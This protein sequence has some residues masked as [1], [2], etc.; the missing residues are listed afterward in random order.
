VT[1][2]ADQYLKQEEKNSATVQKYIGTVK[3]ITEQSRC[4]LSRYGQIN[5][6]SNGTKQKV[7]D[8]F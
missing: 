3:N 7:L 1:T 6:S 8:K 4:I 2:V 5:A